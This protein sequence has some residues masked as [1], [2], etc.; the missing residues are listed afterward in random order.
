MKT[1][2]AILSTGVATSLVA[3]AG[4][5]F[6]VVR[7]IEREH[8]QSTYDNYV[9]MSE[10]YERSY[11]IA[12]SAAAFCSD[13]AK[14]DTTNV[15][16]QGSEGRRADT[17][18]IIRRMADPVVTWYS[19]TSMERFNELLDML[20]AYDIQMIAS[21]RQGYNFSEF[22]FVN[23]NDT[24]EKA[25]IVVDSINSYRYEYLARFIE[26]LEAV[27][28]EPE[29]TV[30]TIRILP[31]TFYD[32][33]PEL[34]LMSADFGETAT[35]PLEEKDYVYGSE[36]ENGSFMPFVMTELTEDLPSGPCPAAELNYD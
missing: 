29:N 20:E 5:H 19:N 24:G 36:L 18:E 23:D 11:D 7:P 12:E 16:F 27:N 3:V 30:T 25:M 34:V 8:V 17:G 28:F 4:M 2:T 14:T 15:L 33:N 32:E 26:E 1:S 35:Y 9:Q 31:S 13:P 6:G 10:L 21:S 22:Y